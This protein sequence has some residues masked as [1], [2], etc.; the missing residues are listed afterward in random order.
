MPI[1][2]VKNM[3]PEEIFTRTVFGVIMIACAFVSWGRWVTGVLGVL[4][5]ISASQGFC[6]TCVL[7]KKFFGKDRR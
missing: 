4:F 5:L 7:Y 6:V 1:R 3:P 2:R